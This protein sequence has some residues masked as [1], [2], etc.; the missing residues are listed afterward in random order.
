MYGFMAIEADLNT[1]KG[2]TF[3]AHGETPG[4]GAEIEKDW[5]QDNFVGKKKYSTLKANLWQ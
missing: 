3:Y 5:F 1:V 2:L 4:L